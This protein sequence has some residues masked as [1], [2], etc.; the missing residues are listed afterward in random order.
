VPTEDRRQ[1][2]TE[3]DAR[4]RARQKAFPDPENPRSR[5]GVGL[6]PEFFPIFR[7]AEGRPA[8]RMPLQDP[9]APGVLDVMDDFI[10]GEAE[11]SSRRGG[12]MGPWEYG[13][14]D[15]GRITFEPG[16]QVEHSTGVY[17]NVAVAI[18][19]MQ[20]VLGCLRSAL[21]RHD[22][23]LASAGMDIWHDVDTVPQQ[24][25]F[26]RYTA[27]ASYYEKRG[28]WGRLMMRH[29][30][31]LQ[32]NLDL[33]GPDL[34]RDRWLAANLISPL[35]TA[36]FA[37]SPGTGGVSTRAQAWQELDPT[38]SGFPPALVDGSET[39]PRNQWA[40][41]AMAA[42]VMLFKTAGGQWFP[43]EPGFNFERWVRLGHPEHGWPTAEDLEYHLT[44][45]F[46]E[47]R[48]RGFIELR[49][50]EQMPDCLRAAQIVLVVAAIYDDNARR[51][52][53]E[54]LADRISDLPD[55]WRRAA[56]QGV[57]DAELRDLAVAA[58]QAALDGV[59][60]IGG[61]RFGEC[62]IRCAR[63]FVEEYTGQGRTPADRLR[64]LQAEDPALALSWASS[65]EG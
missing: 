5:D 27:Q 49:A 51:R 14:A 13:L 44:T 60:R 22:A 19:D 15:G 8:G 4:A 6:E 30:A 55:L 25:P 7:D 56:A 57:G 63:S 39:D 48:P 61:D 26:G 17:P 41:A 62:A 3:D 45:L 33:G 43:G 16:A 40:E 23:V 53:L 50:G 1:A 2:V 46:F 64:E 58:W 20:R 29:T 18:E 28:A 36:S 31:S 54:I 10:C 37:C 59:E 11:F 32:I 35:I 21:D 52:V 12:P 34:W 47:V 65:A 24:L 42:D 38:R 9:D